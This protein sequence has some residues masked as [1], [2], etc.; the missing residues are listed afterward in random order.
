MAA[1]LVS[2][3]CRR[4]VLGDKRHLI[5]FGAFLVLVGFHLTV[6]GLVAAARVAVPHAARLQPADQFSGLPELRPFVRGLAVHLEVVRDLCYRPT[7]FLEEKGN[8]LGLQINLW[9]GCISTSVTTG[10]VWPII[11]W[12]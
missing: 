3:S 2:P 10:A 6:S 5:V 7:G 1:S 11:N 9:R 4:A 12:E 8:S